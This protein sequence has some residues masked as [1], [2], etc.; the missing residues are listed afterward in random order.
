MPNVT[1]DANDVIN[2]LT[3]RY[4]EAIRENAIL[5]LQVA[6][7]ES[8]AEDLTNQVASKVQAEKLADPYPTQSDS[9]GQVSPTAG[10]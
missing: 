10:P 5:T 9:S 3:R 8:T 1:V 7:L 4:A 6:K 2:E